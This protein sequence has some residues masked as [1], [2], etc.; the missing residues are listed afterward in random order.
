MAEPK[1]PTNR[2]RLQEITAGIEQGIKE[3]F[4]S[5]RYAAYLR[6]LS[7]FHRY[8]VN[9]QML[10]H[11][12]K[13]DATLVAGFN[14]WRDQ[15]ERHVKK[16]EKGIK[17]IAPTPFKKRIEEK[18][19]DPDTKLPVLDRDGKAVMEEKE[20]EIPMFR[21]VSVFDVSQTEGM[22]EV[23]TVSAAVHEIAHAKLHNY[24]QE[25][26]EA[27]R[28][29]DTKKPPAPKDRATEE[30]EAESVSYAVC[31]YYGIPTGEN[32]FGYIAGWSK[33]KEL[34][35]LRA[36]LETINKTASGLITDIDRH[37]RDICK[38]WGIDL[39]APEQV[40]PEQAAPVE[41][42]PERFAADLY[43]YM[44]GLHDAGLID[45][46][47]TL[48]PRERAV[49]DM[50]DEYHRGLFSETRDW[51]EN[52]SKLTG[53]PSAADLL[54]RLEKLEQTR[55]A[56]LIFK[57]E[58]NP[59]STG[60]RDTF[61]VQAYERTEN[62][63]RI[64]PR[65]V[66]YIGPTDECR[67]LLHRLEDGSAKLGDLRDLDRVRAGQ[68]LR[69]D[70]FLEGGKAAAPMAE[71]GAL[72]F[73]ADVD[74][75]LFGMVTMETQEAAEKAGY[76]FT[77]G[78]LSPLPEPEAVYAL[79]DTMYLHIQES[80]DG[81]DYTL[82]ARDTL[83]M[84]DGGQFDAPGLSLDDACEEIFVLHD[85]TPEVLERLPAALMDVIDPPP[86]LPGAE[87]PEGPPYD[88]T[89]YTDRQ[90]TEIT[91]GWKSGVDTAKYSNPAFDAM[92]MNRIR[93]GLEQDLPTFYY[94][95]PELSWE[96][97][98]ILK[99]LITE[100]H[101]V[102]ELY[103]GG[104][105]VDFTDPALSLSDM[106]GLLR[107][108]EYDA[109]PKMLY[110]PEQWAEI[111]RGMEAGLDVK[112]YAD[113]KLAPEDMAKLRDTLERGLII[114]GQAN[115]PAQP[116]YEQWSEP[117]TTENA[118]EHPGVPSD[119]VSA[120]LPELTLDEY[121]MPDPALTVDD[122]EKCGYRDGDMLP[123]SKDRALE[124][125]EQDLTIYTMAEGG[126]ASMAFDRED[127]ETHGGLLA[128]PREEWEAAPDFAAAV[129]DRLNRQE[130]REAAFLQCSKDAFAVY[131]PKEGGELQGLQERS[132][133]E[134]EAQGRKVEHENYDLVY[135]SRFPKYSGMRDRLEG[136]F[137][138]GLPADCQRP[139]LATGDIIAIK[140]G[141][142]VSCHYCD[143]LDFVELP[144][145][146]SGRNMLRAAEDSIEQNDNQL[147]GII[148][149]TPGPS[150]TE[151][152]AQVKAGQQISL[153]D[154]AAAVQRERRKQSVVERLKQQPPQRDKKK[155][156]P[157][158]SAEREL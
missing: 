73:L 145:F 158:R 72:L 14:K 7:R 104:R 88:V 28:G 35:E 30:V 116:G 130:Q 155:E 106:K 129:E 51:L 115:D 154:L 34:P 62:T 70:G 128:V 84:L 92:Q 101:D 96:Q 13:P 31:Q 45:Y 12:Q 42:T 61:F 41:D 40:S 86:K 11:M 126:E 29:D 67:A 97:M 22:S 150:V 27:A 37:F 134:L 132:L 50:A 149:N 76:C 111:R 123:L 43:D 120:Y 77:D 109:I 49:P 122:L 9:N 21:P 142:V 55:D 131:Q 119:D 136:I 46:P 114:R 6:T 60:E 17:I 89:A 118:P 25:R 110:T 58:A 16:G 125:F 156:A 59:R 3:L 4:E 69:R 147:D 66:V 103:V 1:K 33:G 102:T 68:P 63:S 135:T 124:L 140:Q 144:G 79:D 99:K 146:L 105:P 98:D 75:R 81:F 24:E 117:A 2:E 94:A 87:L 90:W 83:K 80:G 107:Q 143:S 23:Q 85:L 108:M 65:E 141:G 82:Y 57:M 127:I 74:K 48:D 157:K 148:N 36:S 15:F 91:A 26:Q 19:L 8:S 93:V 53:A 52:A 133:S 121:P 100:G 64:I 47:F 20:V 44:T 10:I 151:L 153:T 137:S 112:Q 78:A 38:E 152:E 32:S 18:K 138:D 71:Q 39:T 54:E 95:K 139:D 5:D 56:A 113:P